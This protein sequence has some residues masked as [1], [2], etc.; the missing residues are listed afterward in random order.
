MKK[1]A[2]TSPEFLK[3][4]VVYQL[5]LRPFTPEG[6]IK[7]ATGLLPHI[8]GLG[9]DI[10][11]L[12]PFVVHDDDMREEFWSDR[13]N[14]SKLGN[15]K[16]PYRLKDYYVMDDE[17]GTDDDLKFFVR[18][19]HELGMKVLFDLVYFHCGPTAVFIDEHPDFVKRDEDGKVITGSWH[20][21]QINFDSAELR[22]YLWQNMEYFMRE[23]NVDGYRCDV[24][25]KVPLDF[26][27]EGRRRMEAINPECIMISEGDRADDQL[28]AFDLNYAFRWK[29][30][31]IDLMKGDK[32][33]QEVR[34]IWEKLHDEFPENARF[35]RIMDDHDIANDCYEDRHCAVCPPEAVEAVLLLNF[36]IDGVP[37]IYNGMEIGDKDRHSIYG[38]RFFGKNMVINWSK[39]LTEAGMDRMQYFR[40]L[41]D[42]RRGVSALTESP[43]KWLENDC[44]GNVISFSRDN[45]VVAINFGKQPL[46][47]TIKTDAQL[48]MPRVH[49]RYGSDFKFTKS[50]L[51]L[52]LIPYGY[53]VI[54]Y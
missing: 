35:L 46:T 16:N 29:Y 8:A 23:F 6:T 21:P 12:C 50:D 28:A 47:V 19:A 7:A 44:P 3:D 36:T 27:E 30:G 9:V 34:E 26:W 45:V 14:K 48:P 54:E 32:T 24:A 42:L 10:I 49:C 43:V 17:Y 22:E 33:A 13:Q 25:P 52:N 37:F 20:F 11:Y 40:D 18:E 38:N 51:K 53:A 1:T 15:P 41:I 2:R 5:Y 31:V 4:S 39:A